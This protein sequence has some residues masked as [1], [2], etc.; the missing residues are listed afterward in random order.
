VKRTELLR[1]IY[2]NPRDEDEDDYNYGTGVH[3][4]NNSYAIR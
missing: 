1:L 4:D 2:T 3:E